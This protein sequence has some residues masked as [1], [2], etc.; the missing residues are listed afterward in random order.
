MLISIIIPTCERA[1]YLR[2]SLAAALA[3]DDDAI[4]IV[5]SDNASTDGTRDLV[6]GISDPRLKYVNTGGRV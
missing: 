3:I 6:A 1:R 5:V 2:H 4:E